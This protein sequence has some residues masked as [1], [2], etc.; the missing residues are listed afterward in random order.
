MDRVNNTI[1]DLSHYIELMY[2][3]GFLHIKNKSEHEV[4]LITKLW[5]SLDANKFSRINAYCVLILLAGVMNILI[6]ELI[7]PNHV[8]H[9]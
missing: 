4:D 7:Q 9:H 5:A 6:P 3:L 2:S 8:N 1:L